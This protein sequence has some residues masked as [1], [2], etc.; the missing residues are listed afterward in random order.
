MKKQIVIVVLLFSFFVIFWISKNDL[1]S[2]TEKQESLFKKEN[3]TST[4][5]LNKKLIKEQNFESKLENKID[6]NEIKIEN[7]E[8]FWSVSD[9]LTLGLETC[10]KNINSQ[11][12]SESLFFWDELKNQLPRKNINFE[13]KTYEFYQSGI[14]KRLKVENYK[15]EEKS[16]SVIIIYSYDSEGLPIKEKQVT[17]SYN[18]NPDVFFEK[19]IGNLD[20]SESQ[21]FEANIE[22]N[23]KRLGLLVSGNEVDTLSLIDNNKTLNCMRET[24]SCR[25]GK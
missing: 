11:I 19:Y 23:G 10:S 13:W 18:S 3:S 21:D 5:N 12:R 17:E 4:K 14:E 9:V 16:K 22:F 6:K 15:S 24:L 25:C 20:L 8:K 2:I 1:S 7:A